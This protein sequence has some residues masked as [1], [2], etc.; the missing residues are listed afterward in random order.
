MPR[1]HR[2]WVTGMTW[3]YVRCNNWED[4]NDGGKFARIAQPTCRTIRV[5]IGRTR[6][7]KF[8]SFSVKQINAQLFKDAYG[9]A[10]ATEDRLQHVPARP[11]IRVCPRRSPGPACWRGTA[12]FFLKRLHLRTRMNGMIP[13][14]SAPGGEFLDDERLKRRGGGNYFEELLARDG[15]LNLNA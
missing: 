11:A 3:E 12:N 9:A 8:I 7:P 10:E 6:R 1:Q 2:V 4:S 15:G 13:T 5:L 14:P